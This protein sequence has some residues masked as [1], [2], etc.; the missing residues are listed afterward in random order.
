MRMEMI[1]KKMREQK[2]MVLVEEMMM[3]VMMMVM[4]MKEEM[5]EAQEHRSEKSFVPFYL[6]N[7]VEDVK[8]FLETPIV[9]KN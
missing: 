6:S 5:V 1:V 8:R 7:T 2:R 4:M 3:K 9:S